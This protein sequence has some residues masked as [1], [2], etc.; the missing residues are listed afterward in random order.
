[1]KRYGDLYE[2]IISPENLYKAHINARRGKRWYKEVKAIE[3]NLPLAIRYL[4]EILENKTYHTSD[5]D[6]FMRN[7]GVKQREIYKLPYYPDRIV[8]WAIIQVIEPILLG[9]L[10][11]DTYSALPGRGVHYGLKRVQNDLTHDQKGTKYCLKLDVKKYYPS[12]NHDILKSIYRKIFKDKDLLWLLDEIIDSVPEDKGVPIG[13]YLSQYSGNIYLS[14]FDH[15]IKE[16]KHVKHYHRYMDDIVI[17]SNSK[18]ELHSL[19]HD[20]EGYLDK[21]L[22]LKIKENWQIFPTRVRGVDFLGYRFFGD[23]TLLRRRTATNLKVKMLKIAN[24]NRITQRDI[25]VIASYDGW[26]KHCD[27]YRLYEK[28]IQPL[29]ERCSK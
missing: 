1:M 18:K 19:F 10:T 7:D 20:I 2:K 9:K 14:E 26:I 4:H 25:S 17:F 21:N 6:I 12:I 22:K 13:N 8:H 27:G 29:K 23:Y 5:Y 24:K 11:A 15:W 28:Y 3:E 16:V